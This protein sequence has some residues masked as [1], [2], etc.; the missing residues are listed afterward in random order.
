[1][2]KTQPI[3]E[4]DLDE[5]DVF[6]EEIDG[7]DYTSQEDVQ[8]LKQRGPDRKDLRSANSDSRRHSVRLANN[9]QTAKR[10]AGIEE[11]ATVER[12]KKAQSVHEVQPDHGAERIDKASESDQPKGISASAKIKKDPDNL[13]KIDLDSIATKQSKQTPKQQR[14][15][16]SQS[17]KVNIATLKL[18]DVDIIDAPHTPAQM[19]DASPNSFKIV[20]QQVDRLA[21]SC[22]SSL[23][24]KQSSSPSSHDQD[25]KREPEKSSKHKL[26][27][28][29]LSKNKTNRPDSK[30]KPAATIF[31]TFIKPARQRSQKKL[32]PKMLKPA[33]KQQQ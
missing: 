1:M 21:A 15:I 28:V 24:F 3:Y 7:S 16:D 20:S 23:Q 22:A 8:Y 11:K 4:D 6:I 26:I 10:L 27:S 2:P 30:Q 31:K 19:P 25:E 29:H 12:I 18:N 33:P 14:P 5:E 32:Q 9:R 17:V 13:R